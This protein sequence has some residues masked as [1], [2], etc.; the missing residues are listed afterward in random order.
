MVFP[1]FGKNKQSG[2][3]S[4]SAKETNAFFGQG[5]F[6]EGSIQF[7]GMLRIDGEFQGE[8]ESDGILVVGERAKLNGE[9][10]VGQL[11]LNGVMNGR[12]TAREKVVLHRTAIL[13]SDVV[14]PRLVV[15]EKA[16][17]NGTIT[18]GTKADKIEGN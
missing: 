5:T 16:V 10:R 13:E 6:F 4:S 7:H 3:K 11:Y 9:F 17:F 18:M 15:D 12:I 14:T 1:M 8:I 2:S